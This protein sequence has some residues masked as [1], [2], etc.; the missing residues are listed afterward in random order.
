MQSG[1]SLILCSDGL[2]NVLTD[3]EIL[4]FVLDNPEPEEL[5]R[6]LVNATLDRGAGDNVTVIAVTR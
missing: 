4:D 2:S 1:D 3:D 5:C 6:L